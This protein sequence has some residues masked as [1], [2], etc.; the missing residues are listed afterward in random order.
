ME[1]FLPIISEKL[2]VKMLTFYVQVSRT[3]QDAVFS[4]LYHGGHRGDVL[5]ASCKE[6][7]HQQ[8]QR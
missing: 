5:T 4:V 1:L 2:S 3:I 6:R 8:A 7:L